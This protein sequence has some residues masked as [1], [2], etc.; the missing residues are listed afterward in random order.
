M[1]SNDFYVGLEPNKCFMGSTILEYAATAGKRASSLLYLSELHEDVDNT[2][3][4]SRFQG[5]LSSE[6]KQSKL[7]DL[8]IEVLYS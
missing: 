4:V 6:C 2:E 7:Q 3:E 8:P 1:G 5:F